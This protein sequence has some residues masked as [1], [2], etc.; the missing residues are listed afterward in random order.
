MTA[1]PL[2][3][4][5]LLSGFVAQFIGGHTDITPYES[6]PFRPFDNLE[7]LAVD[8]PC[9]ACVSDFRVVL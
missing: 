1:R 2:G 6:V 9:L 7:S 5:A 8:P 3:I 4:G